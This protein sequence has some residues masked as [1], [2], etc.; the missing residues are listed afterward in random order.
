[1]EYAELLDY[2]TDDGDLLQVYF[3][4]DY[5]PDKDLYTTRVDIRDADGRD[6][7]NHPEKMRILATIEN[8]L[9]K[10]MLING[11]NYDEAFNEGLC[12]SINGDDG[13]E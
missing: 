1:M 5:H 6:M 11:L 13:W 10:E 8:W 4:F 12:L 3:E 2:E 9:Y 7:N